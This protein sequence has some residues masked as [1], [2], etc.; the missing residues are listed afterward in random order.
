MRQKKRKEEVKEDEQQELYERAQKHLAIDQWRHQIQQKDLKQKQVSSSY[1]KSKL[2]C[3]VWTALIMC[4]HLLL[5]CLVLDCMVNGH[6]SF[7][8][9]GIWISDKRN[10]TDC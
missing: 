9:T 10:E 3:C 7:M 2:C 5:E 1:H 4:L 8:L 6:G